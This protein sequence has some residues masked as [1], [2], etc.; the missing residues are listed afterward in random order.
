MRGKLGVDTLP[1]G[2]RPD[3]RKFLLLLSP[4]PAPAPATVARAHRAPQFD[5]DTGSATLRHRGQLFG[6]RRDRR[7]VDA[8][9]RAD[10]V[11]LRIGVAKHVFEMH[12]APSIAA[13]RLDVVEQRRSDIA[14]CAAT[15]SGSGFPSKAC[16]PGMRA[17]DHGG[18][19]H[20]GSPRSVTPRPTARPATWWSSR[21]ADGG[22]RARTT[23]PDRPRR[24]TRRAGRSARSYRTGRCPE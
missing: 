21:S 2:F 16:Q 18:P 8:G 9:E 7:D 10:A 24:E 22:G 4:P 13:Q 6:Q 20:P 3:R 12:A 15:I 23:H 19:L 17:S 14:H 11:Q 1:V 5:R